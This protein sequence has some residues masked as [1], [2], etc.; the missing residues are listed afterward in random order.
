MFL[1]CLVVCPN[2]VRVVCSR[3]SDSLSILF[4]VRESK[5]API[6]V[7]GQKIP[8]NFLSAVGLASNEKLPKCLHRTLAREYAAFISQT[9]HVWN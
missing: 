6:L 2:M 9:T 7:Y 1:G 5:L 4:A 3:S 8:V